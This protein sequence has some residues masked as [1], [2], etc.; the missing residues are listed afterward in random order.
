MVN[1]IF[2]CLIAIIIAVHNIS[3]IYN[4]KTALHT[5][6][7]LQSCGEISD[8]NH[9]LLPSAGRSSAYY[10]GESTPFVSIIIS[11]Q[12]RAVSKISLSCLIV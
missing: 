8:N 4:N 12:I 7:T 11:E 3:V 1:K 2:I 9:D 6:I 10:I 5:Q